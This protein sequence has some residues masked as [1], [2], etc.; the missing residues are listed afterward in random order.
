MKNKNFKSLLR[1]WKKYLL[2]EEDAGRVMSMIDDLESY[3]E[4]IHIKD[5]TNNVVTITYGPKYSRSNT[6]HGSIKCTNTAFQYANA[7]GHNKGIGDGEQNSC[8]EVNLTSQ[9]T[10][11]MGPLLYEVLIEYISNIKKASLKPDARSVSSLAKSVWYKFD[12]RPDIEKIQLDV[13]EKT[14]EDAT[15]YDPGDPARIE[16]LTPD[17]VEDDTVQFS[18]IG[19]KGEKNWHQSALSRSYKKS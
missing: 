9:T 3:G 15:M 14:I 10:K 11:G 8:W 13:N 4:K 5:V 2:K 6:L 12:D 18:A 1:E 19:D 17:N 16:Q 7:P